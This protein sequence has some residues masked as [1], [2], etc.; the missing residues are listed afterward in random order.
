MLT[1]GSN[2]CG[3]A[4]TAMAAYATEQ[5]LAFLSP[6]VTLTACIE[7]CQTDHDLCL[8]S[9]GAHSGCMAEKRTR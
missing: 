6:E 4:V 7:S 9:S 3:L 5:S 1:P 2:E 8:A